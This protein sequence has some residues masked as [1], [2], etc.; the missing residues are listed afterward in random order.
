MSIAT[1][2]NGH[3]ANGHAADA[4]A[5]RP[6]ASRGRAKGEAA[7]DLAGLR[8]VLDNAPL[9]VMLC[10]RDLVIRY[11]N[12]ASLE[13]LRAIQQYLP[14][15]VDQIVGTN[16]DIF[17]K[18]PSH[19]RHMLATDAMLPHN[20]K[21]QVGPE[22][23]DLT[24][25][26]VYD[27]NGAFVGAMA[28]WEN[29]TDLIASE[30][31][32]REAEADAS[33]VARMLAPL[34]S[35]AAA[36]STEEAAQSA[37]DNVKESFG[38]TYGS[39]WAIDPSDRTL[40]FVAES[41]SAGEVFAEATRTAS[42]REGAGL[43]GSAWQS[44]DLVHTADLSTMPACAR[45]AVA[46]QAGVR[47][48]VCFPVVVHGEVVGTMDFFSAETGDPR[49]ARIDA[50]RN[51]G[52]LVSQTFER[53]SAEADRRADAAQLRH[54]VDIMLE[55]VRGAAAGDLTRDVPVSGSDAIGQMGEGL[56]A[57]LSALR[58]SL[59]EVGQTAQALAAAAEELSA[60]SEQMIG[61]AGG[62]SDQAATATSTSAD[63]ASNIQSVATAAE[64]MTASISEIARNAASAADVAGQAVEGAASANRTVSNLGDSSV[65]IGKVIKVITSIA[66]Q[67]NLL[68][69]NATI[70]AARAGEAGKGFA[71]VANEVKELAKE[72]ARATEDISQKIEAIQSDT[73]GAVDAIGQ[74]STDHQ[75]DQRHPDH[76]RHR[77]GGADRH[78]ERDRAERLG[79]GLRQLRHHPQHRGGV[80]GRAEH[81]SGCGGQPAGRGRARLDGGRAAAAAGSVPVLTPGTSRA[82]EEERCDRSG[83]WSSTT[84]SSCDV[85]SVR[86]S[87]SAPTSRSSPLPRT[88]GSPSSRSRRTVRTWSPSTSRCRS[89]TDCR[90]SPSCVPAGPTCR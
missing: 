89:W 16:I 12:K 51:V 14:V 15:S 43:A 65:E 9:R 69:L 73:A 58:T 19:Q 18:N 26:A 85:W 77:G 74:I 10:D 27:D 23:L 24:V 50:L 6:S 28:S 78:H 82:G 17:H 11:V 80:R 76:D 83:C 84:R 25:A 52:R 5:T 64:E 48:G 61:N 90:R 44:R 53:I 63:V 36:T 49:P 41:G 66:Q 67:T 56:G 35:L 3:G 87:T 20:A 2:H 42:Y 40:R 79:R 55:V 37:L 62:T 47:S 7:V 54:K 38:W 8:S 13:G 57:L 30:T 72:T 29:V 71:V 33:A 32:R 75:P 70:E 45:A 81:A 4:A 1:E 22:T 68:A 34:A 21:I 86:C 39:Y 88:V 59:G 46:K 60:V 31:A